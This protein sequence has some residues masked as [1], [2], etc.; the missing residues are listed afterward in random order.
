MTMLFAPLTLYYSN[1]LKD[2][3]HVMMMD[4]SCII[5]HIYAMPNVLHGSPLL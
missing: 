4:N 3:L 5:K 2:A 1:D